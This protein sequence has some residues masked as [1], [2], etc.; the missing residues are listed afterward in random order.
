MKYIFTTIIFTSFSFFTNAQVSIGKT[1]VTN[2]SVILEFGS[3]S[4]G[5]ILPSVSTIPA[6]VGGTFIVNANEKAVQVF[7][8]NGWTNLSNKGELVNH[9]FINPRAEV[10]KGAIIGARTSSREGVLVLESSTKALVLPK[11]ANPH[12]NIKS[13]VSGTILYDTASSTLAVYDGANWSY[14]K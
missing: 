11:S 9:S 13:P 7:E 14:W 12:T 1:S 4:K 6:S 5:I 2:T 10:G 3:D 8:N